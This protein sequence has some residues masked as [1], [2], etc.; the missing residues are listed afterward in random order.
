MF[1]CS[2]WDVGRT[3]SW[4]SFSFKETLRMSTAF[5]ILYHSHID[6]HYECSWQITIHPTS[7]TDTVRWYLDS[8]RNATLSKNPRLWFSLFTLFCSMPS[9][10]NCSAYIRL[11]IRNIKHLIFR[12][13]FYGP[14]W[15]NPKLRVVIFAF[16]SSWNPHASSDG[17][18]AGCRQLWTS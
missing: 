15:F 7:T 16:V 9:T 17:S 12:P 1:L 11:I 6:V 14:E 8:L 5:Y 10:T 13:C 4:F 3:W 18:P 2:I